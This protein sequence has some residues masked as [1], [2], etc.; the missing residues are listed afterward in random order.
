METLDGQSYKIRT[1]QNASFASEPIPTDKSGSIAGIAGIYNTTLQLSP[2]NID[3]IQ[4]TEE[5]FTVTAPTP[6]SKR[7]SPPNPDRPSR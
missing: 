4:L 1:I 3:D 7:C 6:R 2:R 5:R